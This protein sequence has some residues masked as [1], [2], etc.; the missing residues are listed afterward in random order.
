MPVLAGGTFPGGGKSRLSAADDVSLTGVT[1]V[2]SAFRRR[3]AHR[4][5]LDHF[6]FAG[7]FGSVRSAHGR[8]RM[9]G[10]ERGQDSGVC[11]ARVPSIFSESRTCEH[12]GMGSGESVGEPRGGLRPY[13]PRDSG[14]A[15]RRFC[16][17]PTDSGDGRAGHLV[18]YVRQWVNTTTDGLIQPARIVKDRSKP[19]TYVWHQICIWRGRPQPAE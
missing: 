6:V 1:F 11:L 18:Q 13:P 3:A 8:R 15:A 10:C 7:R 4:F 9:A 14:N 12:C 16:V 17:W 5:Q 19:I 2:Y